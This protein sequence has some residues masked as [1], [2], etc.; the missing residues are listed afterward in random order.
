MF[1]DE[2]TLKSNLPDGV[3]EAMLNNYGEACTRIIAQIN[4]IIVRTTGLQPESA[5][6]DTAGDIELYGAW[7]FDYLSAPWRG[8]TGENL[9]DAR[10]RYRDALAELGKITSAADSAYTA[11]GVITTATPRLGAML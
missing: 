4:T 6:P 3:V 1:I 8:I 7:M 5:N 10:Q 2:N 11:S 9:R